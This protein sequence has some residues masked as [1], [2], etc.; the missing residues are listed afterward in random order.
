VD[1]DRRELAAQ[2]DHVVIGVRRPTLDRSGPSR[3]AAAMTALVG[4]LADL[5]DRRREDRAAR[6]AR[7][8]T[9]PDLDPPLNRRQ[10]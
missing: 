2:L 6:P 1:V 7:A 5:L 3:T 8:A 10:P 9:R 4:R